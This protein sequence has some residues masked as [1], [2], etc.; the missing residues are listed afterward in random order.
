MKGGSRRRLSMRLDDVSDG[1]PGQ[2]ADAGEV[3][4]DLG[5]GV[6]RLVKPNNSSLGSRR[7]GATG[8]SGS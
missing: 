4:P 7:K 1:L 2:I 6:P 5:V 3:V 8:H